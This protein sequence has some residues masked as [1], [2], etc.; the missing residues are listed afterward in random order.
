[1]NPRSPKIKLVSESPLN[2][3]TPL[4][5]L[6]E[7]L[8]PNDLFYVRNHFDIPEAQAKTWKLTVNGKVSNPRTFTLE[9][10]K[11][12][13]TQTLTVLL[14]C[15]GNG[16][17]TL[18]PPVK[19]TAWDL[20]AVSQAEFFGTPLHHLLEIVQPMH[21]A[22]EV[23]FTGAD[24]GEV[25][26]GEFTSYSRSLP[27]EMANHPDV[28]LAWEMNGVALPPSHGYPLRLIV[29]NWYGMA[30]VKWLNEINLID[31]PYDGFFQT[32]DYVFVDA[33]GIP[34]GTPVR[35]MLVRSLILNP[36]K[37]E[38]YSSG[39]IE[40]NG[41]AW[42]GEGETVDVSISHDDGMTWQSSKL[43]SPPNPYGWTR[44]H[45]QLKMTETGEF[46]LISRATDSAGNEQPL[47]PLWNRGGYGNNP[48]HQVKFTIT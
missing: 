44:W 19:G 40:I 16:R 32:G 12:M 29:P 36:S 21:D 31:K 7:N 15:A 42:S 22:I 24:Q 27:L 34:D 13:P 30:S 43:E 11:A 6:Q 2:A 35:E 47:E 18:N 48:V 28:L 10:L 46:T 41:I 45:T 5:A 25:R 3:E 9:D 39:I 17:S 14:E 20:G 26:T 1:M 4:H 23:I 8:T 38:K 37:S 33:E